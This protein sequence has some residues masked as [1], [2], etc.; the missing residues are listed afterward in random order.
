MADSNASFTVTASGSTPLY[1]FWEQ[2]ATVL[3][4]GTNTTLTITNVTT[5]QAGLYSVI[6]SNLV[7]TSNSVAVQL[8]VKEVELFYSNQMLTNGTYYFTNQPLFTVVSKFTNSSSFY[9]LDGSTPS[10]LSTPY[11]GPFSITNTTTIQA[12]GYSADFSQSD[13]A[14]T[15][16]AVP[17][18]QYTLTASTP[19]GGSVAL[20]PP[21]GLYLNGSNVT[22]TATPA[23][24]FSFL[25]WTNGASGNNPVLN[26]TMNT[27]KSIEAVF[28]TTLSNTVAG[29]GQVFIYPVSPLYP[30]GAVVRLSAL[31]Q[32]GNCFGVWGNAASGNTNPLFYTISNASP[33]ISAAFAPTPGGDAA[34]TVLISGGGHVNATPAGNYFPL[35]QSVILTAIPDAGKTFLG[36]SGDAS[37]TNNPLNLTL[38][39]SDVITANFTGTASLLVNRPGGDGFSPQGFRFTLSSDQQRIAPDR[40][41]RIFLWQNAGS[42]TNVSRHGSIHR[43]LGHEFQDEILSDRAW[44]VIGFVSQTSFCTRQRMR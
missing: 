20:N 9:T 39:Q 42:V 4:A 34:L 19:G 17:P 15:V 35:N 22:A 7:G 6:V 26:I 36:W 25:Y 14:D 31:P 33:V 5:N 8:R 37:G 16:I 38:S 28:G 40:V 29:N 21:G 18:V 32:A 43:S 11:T 24:G 12:I 30:Y 1:Y 13:V 23:A 2:G 3:L 41:V 44:A 10:F 27:N